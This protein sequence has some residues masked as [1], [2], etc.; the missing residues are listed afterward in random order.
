MTELVALQPSRSLLDHTCL[1]RLVQRLQQSALIN[2][3]A[4]GS[5]QPKVEL[6]PDYRRGGQQL[7]AVLRQSVETPA[8]GISDSLG[9]PG[10][11]PAALMHLLRC[12]K[13]NYLAQ[14]QGIA[15]GVPVDLLHQRSRRSNSRR[16]L[17][18]SPRVLLRQSPQLHPLEGMLSYETA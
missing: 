14:E 3:L 11:A 12:Q 17:N 15:L 9:D 16:G 18:E 10:S 2:V 5:Q 13:P 1:Q 7:V 4:E 8:D 6:S